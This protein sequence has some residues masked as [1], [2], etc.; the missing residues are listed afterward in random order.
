MNANFCLRKEV[1]YQFYRRVNGP[2]GRPEGVR[3]ISP[4]SGFEIRTLQLVANRY[5]KYIILAASQFLPALKEVSRHRFMWGLTMTSFGLS[6]L[7]TVKCCWRQRKLYPF[8]DVDFA[9]CDTDPSFTCSGGTL[10]VCV[11]ANGPLTISLYQDESG[12][13]SS[14]GTWLFNTG[15][16]DCFETLEY[17]C[18]LLIWKRKGESGSLLWTRQQAPRFCKRRGICSVAGHISHLWQHTHTWHTQQYHFPFTATCFGR[19]PPSPV[20]PETN[21]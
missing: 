4:P 1:R 18:I 2:L 20:L 5:T 7:V 10:S 12:Q 13:V 8:Q 14:R 6:F 16:I 15:L 21:I 11:S 3:Q 17:G 19:T 9:E